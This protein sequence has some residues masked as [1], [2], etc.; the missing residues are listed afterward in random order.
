[1]EEFHQGP[2]SRK[3]YQLWGQL[4]AAG[5]PIYS[6]VF[7]IKKVSSNGFARL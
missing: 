6:R 5:L 4:N 2:G 3:I 1:M 7:L